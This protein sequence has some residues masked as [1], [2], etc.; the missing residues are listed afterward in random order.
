M[1]KQSTAIEQAERVG[2]ARHLR[3]GPVDVPSVASSLA[4]FRKARRRAR[5]SVNYSGE[6]EVARAE[7]GAPQLSQRK[8]SEDKWGEGRDLTRRDGDY[9][10]ILF[11]ARVGHGE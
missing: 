6:Q 5:A 7:T 9:R 11:G 1:R 4:D 8:D 3:N 10:H 2:P